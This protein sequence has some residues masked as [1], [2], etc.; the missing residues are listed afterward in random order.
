MVAATTHAKNK[1]VAGRERRRGVQQACRTLDAALPKNDVPRG[2]PRVG[3]GLRR[4]LRAPRGAQESV[5][6]DEQTRPLVATMVP[7]CLHAPAFSVFWAPTLRMMRSRRCPPARRPSKKPAA[8]K[9]QGITSGRRPSPTR[10]RSSRRPSRGAASGSRSC[11]AA[12]ASRPSVA[13]VV[14]AGWVNV[15]RSHEGRDAVRRAQRRVVSRLD[16]GRLPV[17]TRPSFAA[18]KASA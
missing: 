11:W 8:A 15:T 17:P 2:R 3:G 4:G 10:G 12:L 18:A 7:A 16:P 5:D 14:V 1:D 13:A 9:G 6:C